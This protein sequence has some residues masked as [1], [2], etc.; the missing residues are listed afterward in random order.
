MEARPYEN[1]LIAS[2]AA[3]N[4]GDKEILTKGHL[5]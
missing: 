5:D 3:K 2:L 1:E 4:I